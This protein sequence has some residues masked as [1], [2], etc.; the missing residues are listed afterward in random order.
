[1]KELSGEKHSEKE[2]DGI[3]KKIGIETKSV[4]GASAETSTESERACSGDG[5]SRN[6]SCSH[7]HVSLLA[8]VL[9]VHR[10]RS[11]ASSPGKKYFFLFSCTGP[12]PWLLYQRTFSSTICISSFSAWRQG[13]P[14]IPVSLLPFPFSSTQQ[15]LV[16]PGDSI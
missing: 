2:S 10:R 8:S 3:G 13:E 11:D 14:S 1:M 6:G 15:S 12:K 9:C 4:G 16:L 5:V 7:I